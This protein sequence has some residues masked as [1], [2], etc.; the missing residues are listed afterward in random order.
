LIEVSFQRRKPL[1][2]FASALQTARLHSKVEIIKSFLTRTCW[3]HDLALLGDMQFAIL[4][5][6]EELY[7][8]SGK[9]QEIFRGL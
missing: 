5:T 9:N 4:Q 6:W 2:W 8:I 3:S 1:L 7:Q